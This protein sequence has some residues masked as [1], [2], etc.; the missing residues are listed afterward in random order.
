[1]RVSISQ[2]ARELGVSISTLRRWEAEGKIEAERTPGG[3]RRYD[4]AE[5]RGVVPRVSRSEVLTLAYARVSSSDQKGDLVRQVALL[6]S[7]CC[8][9]GWRYEVLKDLGS[10]LNYKKRGLRQLLQRIC[11]GEVKRLVLTHKDRL[12]RFGSE[13]VFAL[14]EEFQV[15][16]VIINQSERPLSFEEELAQD[17]LEIITVFSAQ[18]YGSRSHKNRKLVETLREAA[19]AL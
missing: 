5:L 17:V 9:H 15:E 10:G 13:L 2:A 19:E 11:A 4:L 18:L 7:F 16:V 8:A 14:C 12:L 6:E 1:M 3:H